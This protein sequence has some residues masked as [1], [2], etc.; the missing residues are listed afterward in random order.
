MFNR[1]GQKKVWVVFL[2]Y[3]FFCFWFRLVFF[4][5]LLFRDVSS[6]LFL[7]LLLHLLLQLLF[8]LVFFYIFFFVFFFYDFWTFRVSRATMTA[9]ACSVAGVSRRRCVRRRRPLHLATPSTVTEAFRFALMAMALSEAPRRTSYCRRRCRRRR[10]HGGS[11][12]SK[13]L[14]GLNLIFQLLLQLV[15]FFIFFYT[16]FY[17]SSSFTT[18]FTTRLL[19]SSSFWVVFDFFCV[20]LHLLFKLWVFGSK[21]TPNFFT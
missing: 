6:R 18:S 1:T 2:F 4:F 10:C 8:H 13:Y 3:I 15:F 14:A 16:F 5:H 19:F 20:R 11:L 21:N 17:N 9:A 7:Q 12:H